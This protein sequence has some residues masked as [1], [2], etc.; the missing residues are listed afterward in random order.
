M[1]ASSARGAAV[2]SCA[3]ARWQA[4]WYAAR[5]GSGC[6]AAAGPPEL[7]N[8]PARNS[9]KSRTFALSAAARSAHAG[10]SASSSAYSFMADPQPAELTTI[11]ST[12]ACSNVSMACRAKP[13]ASPARPECSDSA[14]QHPCPRGMTTSQ[15]SAARTRAVAMLTCGKKTDC[16]QPVSMPTTARRGPCAATR[17]GSRPAGTA[18]TGFGARFIAAPRTGETRAGSP[19]RATSRSRPVRCSARS[20]PA[21]AL[22]RRG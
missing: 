3:W 10:S 1:P 2:T 5:T 21:S 15:P 6:R 4:S 13:A 19:L 20:G 11:A 18:A 16:T 8:R 7:S 22:S 12:S 14:P 17:S 9:A